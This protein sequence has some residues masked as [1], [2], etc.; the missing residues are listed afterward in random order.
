MRKNRSLVNKFV[1]TKWTNRSIE[2]SPNNGKVTDY[3]INWLR[4]IDSETKTQYISNCQHSLYLFED[5]DVIANKLYAKAGKKA[6]KNDYVY[7]KW[8]KHATRFRKSKDGYSISRIKTRLDNPHGELNVHVIGDKES[9]GQRWMDKLQ[10]DAGYSELFKT[11]VRDLWQ[12]E[13]YEHSAISTHEK[14]AKQTNRP[15]MSEQY[16]LDHYC[17]LVDVQTHWNR[18]LMEYLRTL[19]E[20][21]NIYQLSDYRLEHNAITSPI[22]KNGVFFHITKFAENKPFI[23]FDEHFHCRT[24]VF[25]LFYDRLVFA[26]ADGIDS[27]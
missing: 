20:V 3:Q 16:T 24:I 27:W 6:T 14:Y 9:D 1:L 11:D 12:P 22:G 17:H 7:Q 8:A 13:T 23:T 15:F 21:E 4:H 25:W 18:P 19:F 10:C 5:K 26:Y 2:E